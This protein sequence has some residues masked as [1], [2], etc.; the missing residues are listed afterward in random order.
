MRKFAVMLAS[1]WLAMAGA[2]VAQQPVAPA[3][4]ASTSAADEANARDESEQ[5]KKQARKERREHR[6][7]INHRHRRKH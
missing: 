1:A 2:T 5:V 3:R 4:D 7:A 6:K